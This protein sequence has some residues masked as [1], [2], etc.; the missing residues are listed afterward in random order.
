MNCSTRSSLVLLAGRTT[1]G[2]PPESAAERSASSEEECDD[3]SDGEPVAVSELSHVARVPDP[4]A[5]EDP[6]DHVDNEDDEGGNGSDGRKEGHEDGG[7]PAG[8]KDTD[9]AEDEGEEGDTTGDGVDD[10]GVGQAL[11]G[12]FVREV[13]ASGDLQVI[14]NAPGGTRPTRDTPSKDPPVC[15]LS[16]SGGR[17]KVDNVPRGRRDGREEEEDH[18]SKGEEETGEGRRETHRSCRVSVEV[19]RVS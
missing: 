6:E 13:R 17:Q 16:A 1:A 7:Y 11:E 5:D 15:G 9:Q 10:E 18:A 3:C 4:V 2:E 19:G 8:G 14:P 12:D